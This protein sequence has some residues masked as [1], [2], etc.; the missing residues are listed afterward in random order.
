MSKRNI[1]IAVVVGVVLLAAL[2]G[3]LWWQ[4]NQPGKLD[5]FAKCLAEKGVKFYGAFWCPHCQNEKA[6]FGSSQ[7]Y[8]PYVE[9]SAPDGNSQLKVC[10]DASIKVY[11]TFVFA[12][13]SRQEGEMSLEDLASKT[14]CQLPQ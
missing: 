4:G 6:L 9:C 11:P 5:T 1:I 2:I 3:F 12:D 13:G 10:N 7:K 14:G 8:L